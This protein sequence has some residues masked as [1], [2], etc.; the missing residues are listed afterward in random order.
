MALQCLPEGGVSQNLYIFVCVTS[1]GL[2]ESKYA[3]IAHTLRQGIESGLYPVGT[4]LPSESELCQRFSVSRGTVR[5]TVAMLR[6]EGLV[7]THRGRRPTVLN[8]P[9]E[10]AIDEFFSFS[11]WVRAQ[12]R[13]PGQRTVE[14]A[15]RRALSERDSNSDYPEGEYLVHITRLRTID[16]LPTMLERSVFHDSLG[17]HLMHFDTDSGSIFEYLLSQGAPLDTGTHLVDAVLATEID[18]EL[19]EV[20]PG[21]PVLRVRRYT[22]SAD[23]ELLEYSD[24]RYRPDRATIRLRNNRATSAT[25]V[26]ASR[27]S[28]DDIS[29]N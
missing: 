9:L 3:S 20:D 23:G 5:Q 13:E 4:A 8:R 11:A 7:E 16:G 17:Q 22:Q 21:A 18:A 25:G 15:R 26:S 19:L 2:D 24:D 10:H 28:L 6:N 27:A 14:I 29:L 1:N 12:G